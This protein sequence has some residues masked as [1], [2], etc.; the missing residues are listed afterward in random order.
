MLWTPL[1]LLYSNLPFKNVGVFRFHLTL[2]DRFEMFTV[3]SHM[4]MLRSEKN[5]VSFVLTLLWPLTTSTTRNWRINNVKG[6]IQTFKISS[7]PIALWRQ[8]NFIVSHMFAWVADSTQLSKSL[9]VVF[10]SVLEEDDWFRRKIFLPTVGKLVKIFDCRYFINC[11]FRLRRAAVFS[12]ANSLLL[13]TAFPDE[14]DYVN[15]GTS[16]VGLI[17]ELVGWLFASLFKHDAPKLHPIKLG[18]LC[19][20]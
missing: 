17:Y 8:Q 3:I 7:L 1:W 5:V 13:F 12:F 19:R 11:P 16:P 4:K 18:S 9:R 10:E 15:V 6:K 14:C 2:F 20:S